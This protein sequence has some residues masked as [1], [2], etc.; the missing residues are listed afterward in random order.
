MMLRDN[1][2]WDFT[3]GGTRLSLLERRGW[4]HVRTLRSNAL[5]KGLGRDP[6]RAEVSRWSGC[7]VAPRL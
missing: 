2:G 6:L 1:N 7:A 5:A 3:V 4:G